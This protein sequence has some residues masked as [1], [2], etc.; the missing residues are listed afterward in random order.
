MIKLIEGN[1]SFSIIFRILLRNFLKCD[2]SSAIL[3]QK[4]LNKKGR[5]KYLQNSKNLLKKLFKT[6]R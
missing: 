2:I 1:E 6:K 5:I 4:K 3:F